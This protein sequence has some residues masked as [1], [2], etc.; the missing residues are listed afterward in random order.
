MRGYFNA[1][2]G[3]DPILHADQAGR[4]W[5]HTA[6]LGYLDADGFLFIVDRKKDLIKMGGM[7]VWPR[8]IEE[9]L[10]KHP[11]VTEVGVRGFPDAARGEVAVAFVVRRMGQTVTTADLRAWCKEHLAPFKVPARVVFRDELPKSMVGKVLR[12]LLVDEPTPLT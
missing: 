9:V 6:D 12:R 3:T 8:E 4:M 7:Q 10:S 11:A 5:L 2:D 1:P